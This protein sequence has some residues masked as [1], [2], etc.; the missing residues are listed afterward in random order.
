VQSY[1][2]RAILF[3]FLLL[4]INVVV[5]A[6]TGGQAIIGTV[7]NADG[8]ALNAVVVYLDNTR[9]KTETDNEGK[10]KLNA[11]AGEYLLMFSKVGFKRQT[12]NVTLV[13][14]RDIL[15][16]DIVF[17]DKQELSEVRVAGKTKLK[18]RKEQAFNLNVLDTKKLYNSSS[19]LNHAL[20]QT[21]GIRVR[22]EGGVGS[23]FTFS[24]NG[25]SGRQVKFFL[26]GIPMD[27]FG[28]SLTLNNFPVNMAERVE[29]YKGVTPISLGGDAL[30][31]AVNIVTRTNPNYLDVSY[32][33][34]S[35]N[36]HKASINYAY[37]DAKTGFTVRT[38]AFYNYSD[39]DYKVRVQPIDLIS[40]Q[41]G[42][43]QEV[44]RFHDGYKS[45]GAQIEAGVTGKK[46]ADNLLIG[47]IAS[48][49]DKDIQTGVTMD[50]VFGGRTSRSTSLIPTLKYK[51]TNLFTNGLDLSVYSAYNMTRNTFIDTTRLKY[52]WLQQTVPT[53][54]AELSRSQLKNR[55]NE[56]LVTANLAYKLTDNQ[57]ISVNY[58]MTDFRRKSSDV[59]NPDNVTFLYPQKLNKQITGLAWQA[60]YG[61]FTA[62]AFG[63]LYVLN[64][65]SFEQV[66]NGTGV[67][68]YRISSTNSTHYG[69]G[70]AAAYFILPQL[71]AKASYE[72]TYRLPEA[73]ELL[74]DGLFTRRNSALKPERSDNINIGALYTANINETHKFNFEANYIFRNSHD[75]IRLDQQQSQPIDR[76]YINIGDVRT[77]GLE[78]EIRY[79]WKNSLHAAV[80]VTYQ[81]IIDKEKTLSSTNFQGTTI[82]PNY[83]YGYRIPNT[84]YLFGN[85]D[86]GYL[87]SNIG[88]AKNTLDVSYSLNYTEKY[89]LTPHQ[90]G[91]NNQDV[92]PTQFA[93][94]IMANYALKGGRYNVS[95]ECRNLTNNELFDNYL[96]QKPGRSFF[97]KLRYF[98]S[99]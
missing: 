31:G 84:P 63:K 49:N 67:A 15:L 16:P 81:S 90:L 72:H 2:T 9:Y 53:S 21:S 52:N 4:S 62:T 12:R 37:T 6:Q 40:G 35:F 30:G 22:E 47:L 64:A 34:G 93:H 97:L 59:E 51:K 45:I 98:I 55:D 80:N 73:T 36:T 29:V 69:Y 60:N 71:Q 33:Y 96:L 82:S 79:S 20:N 25:F 70:T 75:F 54:T 83:N 27:N 46:Y 23:N 68:G 43:Y 3:V 65:K 26:D 89:Y 38:N 99:K 57:S 66:S 41:K 50:Q 7:K 44:K 1:I 76:Q 42:P 88:G 13:T 78:G 8:Q 10:F 17:A 85:A 24:L 74:G 32:G 95:L 91:S 18:E 39:N 58:V 92:I 87:F 5:K 14:G 61:R 19:D 28:S 94:N 86:L 77:N 48:G 11:P 56:A